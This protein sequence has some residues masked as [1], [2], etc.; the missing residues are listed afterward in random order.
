MR[1]DCVPW[2]VNMGDD[3]A[4]IFKL[5]KCTWLKKIPKR[6]Y[7]GAATPWGV[8]NQQG[9]CVSS[10]CGKSMGYPKTSIPTCGHAFHHI[11]CQRKFNA[12]CVHTSQ[13]FNW[14]VPR[15]REKY[16]TWKVHEANTMLTNRLTAGP[17]LHEPCYYG[18][19]CMW[20]QD[21]MLMSITGRTFVTLLLAHCFMSMQ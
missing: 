13:L 17:L 18:K 21:C 10:T 15:T 20:I 14:L 4:H 1:S 11:R 12:K 19:L 3:L 5:Q 16:S 2:I 7:H 6:I 8:S 9:S